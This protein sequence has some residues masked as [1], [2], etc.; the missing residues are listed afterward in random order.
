M[1]QYILIIT[2]S[3]LV[4]IGGTANYYVSAQD[5]NY[6]EDDYGGGQDGFLKG[7]VTVFDDDYVVELFVSGLHFPTTIDFIGN[8]LLVLEKNTGKVIRINENGEM[9]KEPVLVVPVY[10]YD[11]SGL[12]GIVTAA[13]HVFLYFTE[14]FEANDS[15]K[16]NKNTVY[17]YD[18]DG[19]N[20]TNPILIKELSA[21]FWSH[22]GGVFAKGQNE[23]IYFVIGDD[24]KRTIF[25]N[26]PSVPS[27]NETGSIFKIYTD[28]DNRV[29]LFAVGIR[30]SFG[31]AVDP[32]TGYLWQTENGMKAYD[33]INLVK[34]R[35]NSGWSMIMGP[36]NR[37]DG[38]SDAT[39]YERGIQSL[40]G[41]VYSDPKFSWHTT[42]GVTAIAFP[43]M[44]NF[45][46]YQDWL[47]VGDFNNGRIYKFQLNSDRTEFIF[48]APNL[49][50]LVYD[51]DDKLNEILFA[52][53]F[54]GG[55]TDIKFGN[56]AMYVVSPFNHG[57]I[58]KIYPKQPIP[59]LSQTGLPDVPTLEIEDKSE[60]FPYAGIILA[61]IGAV[62]VGM[63]V[64]IKKKRKRLKN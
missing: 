6:A 35:F 24:N 10:S 14:S 11:E 33:E 40:E 60:E 38:I 39:F 28:D 59:P 4:L 56:D 36:S 42:I 15:Q 16:P 47:F 34:N 13:N 64:S 2:I 61:I 58:Y 17:Q 54:P 51:S 22:N 52:E 63:L 8:D 26:Q 62:I 57:S 3:S 29:E 5:S 18:W 49:K 19:N 32:V 1:L 48:S 55:V 21:D 44:T 12:L 23:E 46:K 30:N 25:Q 37:T 41:F 50:D 20:L 43:D 53:T 45:G 27:S 31:L 7:E 9:D